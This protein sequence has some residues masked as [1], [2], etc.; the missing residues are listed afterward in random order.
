MP[1]KHWL[2]DG[3]E[4]G[5]SSRTNPFRYN[6]AGVRSLN[7]FEP[8]ESLSARHENQLTRAFLVMCKYIP[9]AHQAWLRRVSEATR[10]LR[11]FRP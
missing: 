7:F 10:T 8:F 3:M 1:A 9:I 2:A 5:S 6:T 11:R 4:M